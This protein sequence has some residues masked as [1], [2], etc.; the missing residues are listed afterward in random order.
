MI[1]TISIGPGTYTGPGNRNIRFGKN[2]AIV[3]T[4]G[5]SQTIFDCER[6]DR[7]WVFIGDNVTIDGITLQN[8]VSNED[9]PGKPGAGFYI[10]HST[11]VFRNS[12]MISHDA[13]SDQSAF[14]GIEKIFPH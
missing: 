7:G 9:S 8:C 2:V 4:L 14:G 13:P 12:Q 3:S 11:I 1:Q 6:L 5:S 10:E